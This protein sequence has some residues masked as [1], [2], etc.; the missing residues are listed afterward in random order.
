L[1]YIC[2][3][4]VQSNC[5]DVEFAGSDPHHAVNAERED[6]A[7]TGG[8]VLMAMTGFTI[9]RPR[10]VAWP[11][12]LTA[13]DWRAV[14]GAVLSTFVPTADFRR[15]AL[16]GRAISGCKETSGPAASAFNRLFMYTFQKCPGGRRNRHDNRSGIRM[17]LRQ[18]DKIPRHLDEPAQNRQYFA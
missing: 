4:P 12:S 15:K 9:T 18:I 14:P 17:A 10:W 3:R 2:D 13:A 1:L 5:G 11:N 6:F 7:V 16:P 8:H